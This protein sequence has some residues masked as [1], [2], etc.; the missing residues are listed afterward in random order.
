MHNNVLYKST[1][2]Q[3]I[4]NDDIGHSVKHELDVASILMKQEW[5]W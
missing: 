2:P 4:G 1:F 3:I 5:P